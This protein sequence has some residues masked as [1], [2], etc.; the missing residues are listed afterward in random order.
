MYQCFTLLYRNK[1][2]FITTAL[3]LMV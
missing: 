3:H 1:Q 2:E